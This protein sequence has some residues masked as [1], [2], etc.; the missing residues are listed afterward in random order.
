MLLYGLVLIVVFLLAVIGFAYAAWG[1]WLPAAVW[2]STV[3]IA[4]RY[5]YHDEAYYVVA[6]AAI[7]GWTAVLILSE[8]FTESFHNI[9]R[10]Y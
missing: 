1:M 8:H 4:V 6:A 10:G 2:L 7:F 5:F 9:D 3:A